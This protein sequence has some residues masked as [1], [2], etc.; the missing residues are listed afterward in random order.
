MD[1]VLNTVRQNKI[2]QVNLRT[3]QQKKKNAEKEIIME[4]ER[5]GKIMNCPCADRLKNKRRSQ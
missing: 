3:L 2:N 1:V 4:A 5:E